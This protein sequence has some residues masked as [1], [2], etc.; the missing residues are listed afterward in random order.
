MST[1]YHISTDID[2]GIP[3]AFLCKGCYDKVAPE[4]GTPGTSELRQ[5]AKAAQIEQ[6]DRMRKYAQDRSQCRNKG[7]NIEVGTVVWVKVDNVDRGK[8][9]HKSVPGVI[10][11]VTEHDNYRIACK[12]GVL[13]DFLGG[14][15]I[16]G[17]PRY[18]RSMMKGLTITEK[19]Q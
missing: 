16:S 19:N 18:L 14:A 7:N 11:E 1:C 17:R 3:N 12:G 15:K 5:N 6:G 13:K 10:V 2:D 8:L 9:H 4:G